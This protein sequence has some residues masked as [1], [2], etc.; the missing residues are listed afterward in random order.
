[1]LAGP[2]GR[3][4]DIESQV[5]KKLTKAKEH[6]AQCFDTHKSRP[7]TVFAPRDEVRLSTKGITMP[8]DKDRKS[9]KLTARFYGPFEVLRQTSPVTYELKLPVASNIHPI[10]HVSLLKIA[11]QLK[12]FKAGVLPK[13]ATICDIR[14]RDGAPT[15]TLASDEVDGSCHS[16][17]NAFTI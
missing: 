15:S 9:K 10:F 7:T 1:M 3:I 5:T 14:D 11:T 4:W 6:Q 17:V 12:G 8:W 2:S 13:R 16:I